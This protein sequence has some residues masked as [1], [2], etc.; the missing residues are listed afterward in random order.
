V[1][2]N[3]KTR[4]GL[5][6]PIHLT[7]RQLARLSDCALAGPQT[8]GTSSSGTRCGVEKGTAHA[9][10]ARGLVSIRHGLVKI[11][12]QGRDEIERRASLVTKHEHTL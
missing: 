2:K 4:R 11:T 3:L 9:L 12:L 6:E 10:L 5:D 7:A 8:Y 1:R